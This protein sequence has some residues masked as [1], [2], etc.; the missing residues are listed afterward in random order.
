M[1]GSTNVM[2]GCLMK[3]GGKQRHMFVFMV[4]SICPGRLK[5]LQLQ[6]VPAVL[7]TLKREIFFLKM[8]LL[9]VVVI[10]F[11]YACNK[12]KRCILND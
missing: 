3:G 11:I 8:H 1:K 10:R 2:S 9:P 7:N 12:V 6:K 4:C 5:I